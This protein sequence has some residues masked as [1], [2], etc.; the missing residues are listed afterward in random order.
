MSPDASY[1]PRLANT[2]AKAGRLEEAQK[3]YDAMLGDH[4]DRGKYWFWY[5]EFLLENF[6]DRVEEARQAL[7]KAQNASDRRWRVPDK[8]LRELRKEIGAKVEARPE[9]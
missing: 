6:E 4:P 9:D 5:A 1:Q 3:T 7:E 8:D 2:L